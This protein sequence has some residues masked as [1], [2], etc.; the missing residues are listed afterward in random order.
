LRGAVLVELGRIE[1]GLALLRSALRHDPN[2]RN[3]AHYLCLVAIGEAAAGRPAAARAALAEARTLDPGCNGI[4]R[5]GARVDPRVDQQVVD[6]AVP[7]VG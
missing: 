2:A 3:R 6:A 7:P 1:E 5:A 4:D